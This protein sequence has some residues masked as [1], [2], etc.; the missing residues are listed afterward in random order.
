MECVINYWNNLKVKNYLTLTLAA[1]IVGFAWF[2][3]EYWIFNSN[4]RDAMSTAIS[5]AIAGFIV[6]CLRPWLTAR[7]KKNK[8]VT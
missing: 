6:E 1:A 5:V 8:R 2:A 7:L 3:V 4:Y